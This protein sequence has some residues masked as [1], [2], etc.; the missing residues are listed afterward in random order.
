[1]FITDT[2]SIDIF[3]AVSFLLALSRPLTGS[4]LVDNLRSSLAS[5]ISGVSLVQIPNNEGSVKNIFCYFNMS[6]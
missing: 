1:M 4:K 2:E 6:C 5:D 3:I